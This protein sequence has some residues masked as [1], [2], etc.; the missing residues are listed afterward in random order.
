GRA[1]RLAETVSA[2]SPDGLRRT[3]LRR[4]DQT[5]TLTLAGSDAEAGGEQV[6]R[7]FRAL[8][9]SLALSPSLTVGGTPVPIQA[10]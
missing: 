1:L 7:R 8:C 5:L 6:R 3:G 2:A 10:D 9:D 4:A